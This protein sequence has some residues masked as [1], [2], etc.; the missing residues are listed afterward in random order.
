MFFA[1]PG[2]FEPCKLFTIGHLAL[3]FITII[4][5]AI[6]V[7]ITNINGKRKSARKS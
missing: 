3:F 1:R 7:K 5:V 4:L 6:I 2:E